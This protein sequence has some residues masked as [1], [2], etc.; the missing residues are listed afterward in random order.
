MATLLLDRGANVDAIDG[1]GGATPL[2]LAGTRGH[3]ECVRLLLDRGADPSIET[4]WGTVAEDA[5]KRG[6]A[7]VAAL[8]RQHT[9]GW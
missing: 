1:N 9:H 4:H 3:T 8:L 6:H 5:E 2:F 7:E